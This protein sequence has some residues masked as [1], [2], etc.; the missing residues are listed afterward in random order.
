MEAF[1]KLEHVPDVFIF[2]GMG[3]AHPRRI[4]I[5]SKMRCG[6]KNRPSAVARPISSV[7]TMSRSQYVARGAN[8]AIEVMSSERCYGRGIASSPCTFHPVHLAD[9]ATSVRL[10][11]RCVTKYR[12]HEPIR[13]AHNAAGQYSA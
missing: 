2:D 13:M 7:V 12:L 5:A 1:E 9:L 3:I 11:M 10:V 4:G 6:C 8:C